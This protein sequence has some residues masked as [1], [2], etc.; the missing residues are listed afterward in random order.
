M[1]VR[2]TLTRKF[3]NMTKRPDK[4]MNI[5]TPNLIHVK[6]FSLSISIM[7]ITM[8]QYGRNGTNGTWKNF[9]VL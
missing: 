7:L 5:H 8:L 1:L 9:K 3:Y 4:P 6:G 2:T